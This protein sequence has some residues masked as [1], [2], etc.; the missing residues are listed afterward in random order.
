LFDHLRFVALPPFKASLLQLVQA[1]WIFEETLNQLPRLP[2]GPHSGQR[3]V[4][5]QGLEVV[6]AEPLLDNR[7]GASL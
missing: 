1:A 5:E 6:Q 4:P 7:D 2:P 3:M